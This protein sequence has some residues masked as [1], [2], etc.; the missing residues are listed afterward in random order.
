MKA[1]EVLIRAIESSGLTISLTWMN[2]KQIIDFTVMGR[3][4][5]CIDSARV[6]Q[7]RHASP[8]FR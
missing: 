1:S 6:V 2:G 4:N 7:A 3:G 8:L 5:I